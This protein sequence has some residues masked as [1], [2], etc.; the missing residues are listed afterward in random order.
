MRCVDPPPAQ[1]RQLRPSARF[2]CCRNLRRAFIMGMIFGKIDVEQPAHVV[3][4]QATT[5]QIWRYPSAVAAVV[6][7]AHLPPLPNGQRSEQDFTRDAFRTLA[8]YIGVFGTPQN[9][10]RTTDEQATE[11]VAM[12]APVVMRPSEQVA[13]TAPVVMSPE[14]AQTM[15]FILPSK[16]TTIE[17]A[18]EP[19][20]SAVHLQLLPQRYEA[21]VQFN[22]NLNVTRATPIA[23]DLIKRLN[24]D[25]IDIIDQWTFQGYNPPFTLPMLKRNEI[26]IQVDG[27]KFEQT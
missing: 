24:E 22:G 14:N 12:T 15:K 16:Y 4:H 10:T 11:Q 26:H 9:K 27:A 8:R 5:Y 2:V 20:D 25:G 3:V 7:E 21:V 23:Q 1:Q 13:M 19:T 17:S 18:P 6:N